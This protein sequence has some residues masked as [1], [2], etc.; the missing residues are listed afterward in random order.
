[1]CTSPSLLLVLRRTSVTKLN[2]LL[3][4]P[5]IVGH[6]G[7]VTEIGTPIIQPGK[8]KKGGD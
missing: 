2:I 3:S 5:H 7:D 1:M 6:L 8:M 4:L